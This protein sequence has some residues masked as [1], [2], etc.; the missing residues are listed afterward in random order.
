[1]SSQADAIV[2]IISKVTAKA[3]AD[4]D[5]RS[6]YVANP[7]AVLKENGLQIPAGIR[8]H[9]SEGMPSELPPSTA[10]DVYLVVPQTEE[11]IRDERLGARAS[12]S[13]ESTSSTCFTIPSCLSCVSTASTNSCK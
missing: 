1:M 6:R 12:A 13:C 5:F 7:N 10:T 4:K 8:F 9:V 3:Q 11:T 2:G